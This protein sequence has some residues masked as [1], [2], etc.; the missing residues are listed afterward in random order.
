ML[1]TKPLSGNITLASCLLRSWCLL[2]RWL[3]RILLIS[4]KVKVG[5]I[6]DESHGI[7]HSPMYAP[8]GPLANFTAAAVREGKALPAREKRV[9]E[10]GVPWIYSLLAEHRVD[11]SS[12]SLVSRKESEGGEMRQCSGNGNTTRL[13]GQPSDL[14]KSGIANPL[15]L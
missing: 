6:K 4:F 15:V 13:K 2:L 5:K 9:Q 3:W 7:T 10:K 1:V 11:G 12:T 8:Q 14:H